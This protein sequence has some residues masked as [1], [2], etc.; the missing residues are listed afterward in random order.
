MAQNDVTERAP[1]PEAT[2]AVPPPEPAALRGQ[3][4]RALRRLRTVFLL[5]WLLPLLGYALVSAYLYRENQVEARMRLDRSVRIAQ[6]HALKM[7]ETNQMLLQRMLDLVGRSTD[8]EIL[9]RSE[10][11]HRRL[12]EMAEGLPQ[13]QGLFMISA[14]GRL[15]STNRVHPPPQQIDYRDRE[16]YVAH[17]SGTGPQVFVTEQIISR[18]TG[19]PFFDMSRRRLGRDGSF[20]GTVHV[21]LRP[22]YLTSFYAEL[23]TQEPGLNMALVRDDGK[24]VARWPREVGDSTAIAGDHRLLAM[25]KA[26]RVVGEDEGVSPFDGVDR[27]RLF[28][29]LDPYALY[30]VGGID[31]RDV[32]AAWW[33]RILLLA[34]FVF[35]TTLGFAV[36]ARLALL[37]TEREFEAATRLEE[38]TARRQRT[39]VALLH[40]QKLEALGRLTGGVAHDFNNVLTVV[41]SNLFLIRKLHP[42][43]AQNPRLTAIDRAVNTGTRL[44]RQLLAFS[45]RQALRPELIDLRKGL[46]PLVD[47]L[48]PMLGPTIELSSQ[49]AA[50]TAQVEVD[51]AELELALINLAANA[52]DA[53][54]QGGRLQFSGRNALAGEYDASGRA[55]VVIEATDSGTGMDPATAARA[56]EPFFTTKALGRGT[57][58]GLSQVQTLAQ[59]AGGDARVVAGPEGGTRVLIY[60]QARAVP[61]QAEAADASTPIPHLGYRVLM[62]EDNESVAEATMNLLRSVGCSVEHVSHSAAAL[63]FLA[64]RVS[65]VDVVLSDIEMPGGMDGIEL[66]SLLRQLYPALPVVLVTGYAARIEQAAQEKL[67][68]LPK[69]CPPDVLVETLAEVVERQRAAPGH[70]A[71]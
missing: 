1:P 49:V 67:E 43:L 69:P 21:S 15:Q 8:D 25:F 31:R 32:T 10:E 30:M 23:A 65:E 13:V 14:E 70:P 35:P 71:N 46:S 62:V 45:R 18:A 17:R 61:E 37:R 53:M 42:D 7:F 16:W 51:P 48:R 60:L 6:E 22:E 56:F 3:R 26:S 68:V 33:Q 28:R 38:E 36:M 4:D 64:R 52:R 34:W 11:I 63:E 47:M 29:K 55:M 5:S 27:I 44:T 39:E 58:L 59:S 9:A 19:E 66:A 12:N 41:T 2:D 24:L 54:P 50:D 57:G 20:A 40:S